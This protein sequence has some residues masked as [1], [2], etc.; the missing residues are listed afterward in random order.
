VIERSCYQLRELPLCAQVSLIDTT[1]T[2]PGVG[3][4]TLARPRKRN[5]LSIQ[6]RDEL[7]DVLTRWSD[8]RAVRVAVLTGS[9][10]TFCAG[11][12]LDEFA[13]ASLSR[14]IAD[15]SRRYHLGVWSFPKPLIAAINGPALAGGFDLAVL[16]DL[17]L[18][19]ETASFGHPEIKFGAPPLFTP[20]RWIVGDGIARELCL[21]GRHI[22]AH[23][24][25]R[26]G[27]ANQVVPTDALLSS[28]VALARE[29]IEAPQ[30]ALEAT[31]AYLTGSYDR[32]FTEAFAVEHDYVFDRYL[33]GP[34]GPRATV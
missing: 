22:D 14:T 10:T 9:G 20:L 12:D 15:S 32:G 13:D 25:H 1:I 30:Y 16:C 6:L 3:V 11:F 27:L 26:I 18:A 7:A 19:S 29:I 21:T 23:E 2:E 28:A 31:K 34:I 17:R 4:I 8:D 24:A 33:A 5:A